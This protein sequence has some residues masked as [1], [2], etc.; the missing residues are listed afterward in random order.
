MHEEAKDKV[1]VMEV[2]LTEFNLNIENFWIEEAPLVKQE[3]GLKVNVKVFE[4]QF[5]HAITFKNWVDHPLKSSDCPLFYGWKVNFDELSTVF[6]LEVYNDILNVKSRVSIIYIIPI[7]LKL[8]SI[9]SKEVV[10]IMH[11]WLKRDSIG[12]NVIWQV[13]WHCH[14][15]CIDW[16][17]LEPQLHSRVH[18]LSVFG[19][20]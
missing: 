5:N 19:L 11:M 18:T 6:L 9:N 12:A 1:V 16:F 14:F 7:Y 10:S 17:L 13:P 3:V 4:V 2:W 8:E 20:N 15:K